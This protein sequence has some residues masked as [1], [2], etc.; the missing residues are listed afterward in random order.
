MKKSISFVILVIVSVLVI[1]FCTT[2]TVM[3][4][5][6]TDD[7]RKKQYYAKMEE[8]YYADIDALLAEKG[9]SG[10]GITIRWVSDDGES[11]VYT[12]MI[13]HR[14][15]DVLNGQEKEALIQ[16]LSQ[17]EFDDIRCSFRYEFLT[18]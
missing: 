7:R 5:S 8:T 17:A 2:Q 14:C 3:S 4:Q 10:S 12:V 13:H 6:K 1:V 16:E 9:Y 15:I 18:V 11:R